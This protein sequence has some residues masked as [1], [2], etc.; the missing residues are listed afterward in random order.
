MELLQSQL[1]WLWSG[2]NRLR[3][4]MEILPRERRGEGECPSRREGVL[5]GG[6]Y[7]PSNDPPGEGV[8]V[9]SLP[10]YVGWAILVEVGRSAVAGSDPAGSGFPQA[11]CAAG[12]EEK[13]LNSFDRA[14]GKHMFTGRAAKV[15][16]P[17]IPRIEFFLLHHSLTAGS[18]AGSDAH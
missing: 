10:E 1:D 7:P 13:L 6:P 11:R 9:S 5:Q 18:G 2:A 17:P 15:G 8:Q 12:R 3:T 14:C 4:T 16:E